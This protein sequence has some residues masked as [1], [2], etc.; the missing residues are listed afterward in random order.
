MRIL[1]VHIRY[2]K[3]N[4]SDS[5]H[6]YITTQ[7]NLRLVFIDQIF[8][9][10]QQTMPLLNYDILSLRPRLTIYNFNVCPRRQATVN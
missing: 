9:R 3:K 8:V 6:N 10:C 2:T 1:I 4:C 7:F 5:I